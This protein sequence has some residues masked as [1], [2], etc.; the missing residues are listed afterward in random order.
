M[1]TLALRIEAALR[2]AVTQALGPEHREADLMLRPAQNPRFGDYQANL[3][4]SLGKQLG[5]SPRELAL[6]IV[7]A[8]PQ[9]PLF[10]EVSVAGPGF[11]NLS[12]TDQAL[13]EEGAAMLADPELHVPKTTAP[14]VVVIDYSS[15]NVAKEMHVGHIR[16]TVIGD[17]IVRV[18]ERVGHRVLRQN[19][20]GDWGTQFGMLIENLMDRRAAGDPVDLSAACDLN[21]VYREAKQRFDSEPEFQERARQRVVAL[22]SGDAE[23]RA[24]WRQLVDST[25]AYLDV[26]YRRLGVKLEPG[27][28]CGESH[29]NSRLQGVVERL[30]AEGHLQESDG[31]L[32]VFPRG[33]KNKEGDPLPMIVRK[34]DGGYLYATTD[35]AAVLYRSQDL[36]GTHL[37]YVVGLPQ[38]TH[39]EMLFQVV[40][41]FG[42]VGEGVRL[43]HVGF[44]SVLGPD[45]KM[46]KTR[47]GENIRLKD[48]LDEAE[49]RASAIVRG[50]N[51]ELSSEQVETIARAVGVGALKYADLSSDRIKDYVFDW[52]RM[53]AFDGNTAPYLV[54]A[55]VRIQSIFRKANVSPE[56]LDGRALLPGDPAERALLLTLTRYGAAVQAVAESLEPHRLCGYL[57]DVASAFHPFY[58]RC[59]ILRSDVPEQARS[60]RLVL[61]ALTARVL[62]EGLDLL[63]IQVVEQM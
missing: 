32:C 9:E 31:A 41:D 54:N 17:A 12:L 28:V 55:Y 34:A 2:D 45:R 18:L 43:Q 19:H 42:W 14:D 56:A 13:A 10:K 39:L 47:A 36:G 23:T 62:R 16:S 30:Q 22:Q 40:R 7:Q 21:P 8:L 35:L 20:L 4:M 58:E 46:L 37:L 50:K 27:D 26:M 11:I 51:P 44:G 63:G 53:L 33:Y 15:P 6:R 59:P 38:R 29:Y 24:L 61:C 5:V 48:L 49:A 1:S 3:A 57:Y 52:E 60:S 25:V